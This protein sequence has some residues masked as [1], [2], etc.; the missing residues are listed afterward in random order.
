MKVFLIGLV[1][2]GL[3]SRPKRA[4]ELQFECARAPIMRTRK[5]C[6]CASERPALT[7]ESLRR[8]PRRLNA[9]I[10]R[11]AWIAQTLS[12]KSCSGALIFL[13]YGVLICARS[14]TWTRQKS[15]LWCPTRR[16]QFSHGQNLT[17]GSMNTKSRIVLTEFRNTGELVIIGLLF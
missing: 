11:L 1:W 10:P 3:S 12:T 2:L 16:T 9:R 13:V 6:V 15:E 14:E 17:S 7:H 8:E 4:R 5:T